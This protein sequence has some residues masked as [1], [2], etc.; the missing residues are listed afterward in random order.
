M[1]YYS[2]SVRIWENSAE[3]RNRTKQT[4][5][6]VGNGSESLDEEL[7]KQL[8]LQVASFRLEA[9]QAWKR[10]DS[11]KFEFRIFP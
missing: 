10:M 9:I 6:F 5:N 8:A 11:K 4:M 1:L 7:E 3:V 2:N